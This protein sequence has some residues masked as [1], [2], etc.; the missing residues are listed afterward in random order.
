MQTF[1]ITI[2]FIGLLFVPCLFV[3]R[4]SEDEA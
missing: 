3:F 1:L 2:A 4:G